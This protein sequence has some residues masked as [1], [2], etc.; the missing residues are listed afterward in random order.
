MDAAVSEPGNAVAPLLASAYVQDADYTLAL[1][2]VNP[3]ANPVAATIPL[4]SEPQGLAVFQAYVSSDGSYWQTSR[5]AAANGA[6]AVTVPGY[7]VAT[8]Y[9]TGLNADASSFQRPRT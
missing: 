2:L 1:V 4:P 7:G 9:S 5:L 3:S 8:L 6:V